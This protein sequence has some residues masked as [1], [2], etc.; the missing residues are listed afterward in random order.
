MGDLWENGALAAGKI[1]KQYGMDE[2]LWSDIADPLCLLRLCGRHGPAP[3]V[4]ECR[5][6][7]TT[8]I[9]IWIS[10]GPAGTAKSDADGSKER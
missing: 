2:G 9:V 7:P 8:A 5:F 6:V 4:N 10:P 1:K 3:E